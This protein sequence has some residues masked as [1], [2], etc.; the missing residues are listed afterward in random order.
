MCIDYRAL[1]RVTIKSRYPIPRADELIDQLRGAKF[2]SKI[3]LR[4]GYLQIRVNEADCYKT[5]FPTR[6]GSYEYTVMPFGLTN[7]PSTFQLTM[8]EIFRPLLD[9]C[10]IVYL[11]DILIYS[12]TREAHLK[13]LEAVFTLLQQHRLITK[14]SKCEFLK[15]ELEF[16][17]HVISI[18]GVKIDPKQIATIQDW[19][20]PAN[21]RELQS[22]LGF[23]SFMSG[24][25]EQQAAFDQLKLFLTIPPVLR[26]AD[27]HR[28]F[29]LITDASDLAVGAVLL[30]DFGEGLQPI[31]YESRKLNPAE[32]NYPV[33]DKEL[34]AIVHAFKVWRCYLTGADVTVRTDHKS[35]QF[36]RAQ[37]TL[38]PRQ[39]RWLD[40]LKSN[41]HYRVTY[42]RGASNIADALTRPSVHTTA[43][44]IT[45]TN[46]LLTG[47]FT[48]GYS[49]DP[50]FMTNSHPQLTVKQGA[51]YIKSGTNR[52]W[53]PACRTLREL[54]IQEAHDSN[55]SGHY[56]IDKIAKLLSRNYYWPDLLT[57]VQQYV[58]SCATCQRMKLSRLRPAGLMQP[59]EPPS[60]PW[61]QVTMDFVTGLPAGP[62]GND[63]ILVVV[64]RLTKMAHFAAC[65]TTITA[66]QTAKLFLTNIVR[67][68]GIPSAIISDR[69]PRFTSNFW[70]KTWQQY[71]TRL[72]LSTAYHPQSDGQTE[73]TNQ[74][75]EQLIRTTCTDPAQWEDSLPLIEFA[76][77]NAPSATT[78]QS[79]FFLNYGIDP[80]TPLSP[81]I[82]NPAPRSQQ[83]V[84]NLRQSQHKAADAIL[85]ANQR[86]KQQA[87]RRRRDLNLA[88]GQLVLLDTRNLG[89][90]LPNNL[91]PRFCGP[92]RIIRM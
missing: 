18:D 16:L 66:E 5:A 31:A 88:P 2:F 6:Y 8:N 52:F 49:T 47:L 86:A 54:L 1:N 39:I 85:K 50:F 89:I 69:D 14:G 63:A 59:L 35:L 58:T 74:T 10:A 12:T 28:P 78:T 17:G 21:L 61:Q 4:G 92:F 48:H 32:R 53:V 11:D 83:F 51:Y 13:D 42:K 76:Y 90:P 60:R 91:R 87:D 84:E 20:P 80:T 65:K 56:G 9:K 33:H 37:P 41:F 64:D 36:I 3:D 15:Q 77:N 67:L 55:F 43:V 34:L 45:Q 24:G 38:N 46:P 73:R 40:Y 71:G 23:A 82:E 19:K 70:T 25:G 44:L 7:A 62:S 30:Q 81:P 75:M 57:D 72:H 26:I 79:P 29:E 22:F 68:H 27:P